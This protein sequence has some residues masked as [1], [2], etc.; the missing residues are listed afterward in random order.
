MTDLI[1]QLKNFQG[2][3]KLQI[4]LGPNVTSIVGPSDAGKSSVLRALRWLCFNKPSG[5]EFLRH[6]ATE[7]SV[8]LLIDG[9]SVKRLR[10][11]TDNLYLI[12]GKE[13]RSFGSNVP[14]D[15]KKILNVSEINFQ[16]QHDPPFWMFLSP[17]E[18]SKQ[19]NTVVD[20][21][22][23]DSTLS[24][25]Q[26]IRNKAKSRHEFIEEGLNKAKLDVLRLQWVDRASLLVELAINLEEELE[27]LG[28]KLVRLKQDVTLIHSYTRRIQKI[29]QI[30]KKKEELDRKLEGNS[31]LLEQRDSLIKKSQEY[32]KIQ[33]QIARIPDRSMVDQIMTQMDAYLNASR[34]YESIKKKSSLL[35]DLKEQLCRIE[36]SSTAMKKNL[37]EALKTHCP[38]CGRKQTLSWQS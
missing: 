26:T 20:L 28:G 38:L 8:E 36:R 32:S 37:E 11:A 22:I 1:L 30:L 16:G 7:V 4:K 23:I 14:D 29:A 18:V 35:K 13:Y 25:I 12:D 9:R 17:M 3:Q 6:G 33:L 2:H 15:V 19:L 5:M 34:R 21:T 31:H 10:N 27:S 24:N